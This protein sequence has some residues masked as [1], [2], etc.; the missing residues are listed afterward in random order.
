M[1]KPLTP[2]Q[3]QRVRQLI[4]DEIDG[5]YGTVDHGLLSGLTDDDHVHYILADGGREFTGTVGGIEPVVKTDF[6]TKHYVDTS[7]GV[8]IDYFFNNTASGIGGIYYD[9]TDNDLGGIES[10]LTTA[11]LGTGDG[12]ALVTFATL[13]AEPGINTLRAS[14]YVFHSHAEKTSGTKPVTLYAE[15]YSRTSGGVETLI[16]TSEISDE[17]TSKTDLDLHA[18]LTDNVDILES[19]RLVVKWFANVGSQ[20]NAVDVTLYQ[21]GSDDSHFTLPT[22]SDILS[23]IFVRLDEPDW[24]TLIDGSDAGSLHTHNAVYYT[25]TEINNFAFIKADATVP[26][27]DDYDIGNF[28]FQQ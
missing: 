26:M 23:S 10:S 18:V 8:E 11:G 4:E 28:N 3:E 24:N 17:I 20:G 21:E 15:I 5:S 25:E 7:V 12:Q 16:T 27:T 2:N 1:S 9:M 14:V 22:T 13:V 6:V 19:D